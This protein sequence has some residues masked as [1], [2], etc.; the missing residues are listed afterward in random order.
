MAIDEFREVK[1]GGAWLLRAL[2]AMVSVLKSI[3]N[4]TGS[5]WEPIA[6]V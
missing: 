6:S 4:L 3:L 1:V 5:Q 2:Y